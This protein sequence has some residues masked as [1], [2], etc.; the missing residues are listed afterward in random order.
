MLPV[1]VLANFVPQAITFLVGGWKIYK[2]FDAYLKVFLLVNPYTV[3][4]WISQIIFSYPYC[5]NKYLLVLVQI[6]V[7]LH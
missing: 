3:L 5:F 4:S 6:V 2:N 7:Y 1:D